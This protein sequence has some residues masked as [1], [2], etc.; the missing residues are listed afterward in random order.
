MRT[1]SDFAEITRKRRD[2]EMIPLFDL[3]LSYDKFASTRFDA[4]LYLSDRDGIFLGK[5]YLGAI[6]QWSVVGSGLERSS[7]LDVTINNMRALL[8]NKR[9]TDLLRVGRNRLAAD[10][11]MW[12]ASF[13]VLFAGGGDGDEIPLGRF[14]L[15]EPTR[16]TEESVSLRFSGVDPFLNTFDGSLTASGTIITFNGIGSAGDAGTGDLT[17]SYSLPISAGGFLAAAVAVLVDAQGLCTVDAV[18]IAG[19]SLTRIASQISSPQTQVRLEV[20]GAVAGSPLILSPGTVT[21]EVD[22]SG[23]FRHLVTGAIA[24]AHVDQTTPLRGIVSTSAPNDHDPHPTVVAPTEA[25]DL[26]LDFVGYA[27][28]TLSLP[29]ITAGSGQAERLN[30]TESG[31]PGSSA[32]YLR[33]GISTRVGQGGGRLMRWTMSQARSW[34]IVGAAVLPAL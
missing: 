22:S 25:G 18:R 27:F 29:S 1:L 28:E 5:Q 14:L 24:L 32:D 11:S 2:V 20:W 16:I 7:F 26:A 33:I 12:D 3:V 30:R 21:V 8:Y 34:S 9:L 17:T 6:G 13:R 15:E 31:N 4:P 19:Q 23:G 10:P